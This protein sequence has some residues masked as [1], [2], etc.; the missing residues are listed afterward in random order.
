[1]G[2][3]NQNRGAEKFSLIKGLVDM[4]KG[5]RRVPISKS[6]TFFGRSFA[7]VRNDHIF[8]PICCSAEFLGLFDTLAHSS[9]NV[10]EIPRRGLIEIIKGR[11]IVR[12]IDAVPEYVL[13]TWPLPARV[14]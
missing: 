14:S 13:S 1:M 6:I 8:D 10:G 11:T 7:K 9:C 5:Q 2:K 4:A 3:S 12:C